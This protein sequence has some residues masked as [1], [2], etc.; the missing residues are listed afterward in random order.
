LQAAT[1]DRFSA[2][3]EH[4]IMPSLGDGESMINQTAKA[5][6]A[7]AALMALAATLARADECKSME[8]A[9]QT[10]INN[11]DVRK[12]QDPAPL[13]AAFGYGLGLIKS[14]RIVA[15]ECLEEG[16]E[17]TDYLAKVDRSIR[18]LQSAIDQLCK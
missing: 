5:V 18:D 1:G 2:V 12:D 10:L 3:A 7:A 14:R 6:A 13:C 15:D 16:T 17:R 11:H 4:C 8:T 9:I